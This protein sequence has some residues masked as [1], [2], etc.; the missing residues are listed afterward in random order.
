MKTCNDCY[1]HTECQ[2][3]QNTPI[4]SEFVEPPKSA[5]KKA[6]IEGT[7]VA[8]KLLLETLYKELDSVQSEI[9]QHNGLRKPCVDFRD[10]QRIFTKYGLKIENKF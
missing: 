7:N 9:I 8:H 1:I 3:M 6:W 10:I 2:P 4:C 5:E